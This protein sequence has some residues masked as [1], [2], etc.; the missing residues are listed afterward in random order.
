MTAGR[1][2]CN[3]GSAGFTLLEAMA[4]TALMA[5][6]LAALAT[7][8]AQ[9]LPNWNRGLDRVQ[10]SERIA[11]AL[12]RI[13]TDLSAAEFVP[14][15]RD[16]QQ[17]AFEATERSVVFVRTALGPNAGPSLDLVR[18]GERETESGLMLVR[19]RSLFMPT[20]M[21]KAVR[22]QQS[23]SDPVI[24]L[25]SPYVV[26]FAF[27]GQD[28]AWQTAWPLQDNLPNA[29]RI[30]VRDLER[31]R[32]ITTAV[33]LP[34]KLSVECITAKSL[35]DCLTIQRKTADPGERSNPRKQ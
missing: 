20:D 7:I 18:I 32:S 4:A 25:R 22:P 9:W 10:G 27:A 23:F 16:T 15:G 35:Q 24:L 14:A 34:A 17:A 19:T 5:M 13:T 12:A 31:E 8:T 29:V 28:R 2:S 26:R 21:K 3:A 1:T 11:L 6:I 33:A 30:T